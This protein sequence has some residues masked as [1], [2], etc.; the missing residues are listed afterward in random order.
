MRVDHRVV[1]V[2]AV[3]AGFLLGFLDFVWIK[4]VPYP[5]AELG[6]SSAV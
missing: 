1:A 2:A 4:F 5:F 3:V 6:N